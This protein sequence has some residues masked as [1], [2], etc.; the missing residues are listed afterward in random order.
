MT[1]L[2]TPLSTIT[3]VLTRKKI[4]RLAW[5][6]RA[7]LLEVH[8][9]YLQNDYETVAYCILKIHADLKDAERI[10]KSYTLDRH[11]NGLLTET[12]KKYF[13]R[14]LRLIHDFPEFV[15]NHANS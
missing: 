11:L 1:F 5:N 2:R 15:D 12:E 3:N 10:G 6:I 14:V 8:A 9:S 7:E 4:D 13:R